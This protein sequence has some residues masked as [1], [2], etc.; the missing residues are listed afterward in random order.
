MTSARDLLVAWLN[1][2]YAMENGLV[3]V[4][5]NH[6]DD[7]KHNPEVQARIEQHANETQRHGVLVKQCLEQLGEKPSKTKAVLGSIMGTLQAPATGPF[8]DE[9]VK[10]ALA[11]Y[12]TEHF[13]IA[14]YRAL[15][16]A[17][18]RLGQEEIARTCE[19]ILRE[20]EDM[21]AFLEQTL[22]M[23]V[24]ETLGVTV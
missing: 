8:T 15:S 16:E 12:A 11:D 6:A 4:L 9:L 21:A 22:P 3:P 2:A 13:E 20:E 1:D 19:E 24:Q 18:R 17:A 7:A 23:T 10:N 14:A 5:N